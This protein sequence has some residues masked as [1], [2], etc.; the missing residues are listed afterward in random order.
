MFV[1]VKYAAIYFVY[2]LFWIALILSLT[3]KVRYGLLFLIPLIPL[4]NVTRK[5]YQFPFGNQLNDILLICM[6]VGWIIYKNTK[7]RPIAEKTSYN[8]ILFLYIPFIYFALW[9]GSSFLGLQAPVNMIDP[10]VQTWKNYVILLLL[11]FLVFNNIYDRKEMK[12]LLMGM[13]ASMFLM[14]FYTMRQIGTLTAWW[15]RTKIKGTFE[16]LGANE[17]AAFYATYTFVLLGLFL[18]VKD[19]RWRI[20]L[21]VLIF[22][23]F[24]CDL[25]LFSRGAYLATL[26]G[27][28]IIGILRDKRMLVVIAI[29]LL[30]WSTILPKEV[31][32]RLEATTN[33][34][35]GEIDASAAKRITYW[36]ESI[37]YF[38]MNP[39]VGM[40]FNTFTYVGE[41]RDTHNIYLRT[42]AE[43]GIIG[44]IFLLLIMGTALKRGF[45][46]FRTAT[47]TFLK[48]LGLGFCACVMAVMVGNLFGDRW[49]YLPLGAYFWVF[50][51][52]VERGNLITAAE[53]NGKKN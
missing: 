34:E 4:E 30:F 35:T 16:W 22:Q 37:E 25:F 17:I 2:A 19:K 6:I 42:L 5:L 24:F 53:K 45:R 40:G 39:L 15:N 52:L 49:T 26:A 8:P 13:C 33:V 3:G 51:G 28:F 7:G 21:G 18:L 29:L 46:L 32:A 20:V 11:F 41:K 1:V 48:G 12:R 38:R 10:R 50:L 14:N 23:N 43:Q 9:H 36:E 31:I 44:L 47:D 27:L